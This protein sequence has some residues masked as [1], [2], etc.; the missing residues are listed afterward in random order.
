MSYAP[1]TEL[2]SYE[3]WLIGHLEGMLKKMRQFEP[4]HWDWTP[5][6]AAPTPRTVAVHAW[7]WLI[8][9]RQHIDEPDVAKHVNVPEPP[10]DDEAFCAAFAE[11]TE[12]WRQLLRRLRPEDLVEKRYQFG[13]TDVDMNIRFFIG[14][15]VQNVIYKHGQLSEAFYA[16]GCDGKQPYAA[17]F[18]N[19]IYDEIRQ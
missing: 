13:E 12:N 14:H 19:P 2:E 3:L 7:Q 8:C 17:P 6:Q 5:D 4:E 10:D 15:M 18:P 1:T 11:E 16:L 9:D